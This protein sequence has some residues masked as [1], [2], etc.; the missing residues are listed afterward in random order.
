[1]TGRGP[2]GSEGDSE[3]LDVDF[4]TA[5]GMGVDEDEDTLVSAQ[6]SRSTSAQGD[7]LTFLPV[8]ALLAESVRGQPPS[9]GWSG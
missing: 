6:P 5:A 2:E 7:G 3:D 1:M 9:S 8:E 4:T